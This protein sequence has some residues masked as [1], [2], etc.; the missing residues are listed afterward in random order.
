VTDGRTDGPRYGSICRNSRNQRRRLKL[1]E[2]L[3]GRRQTTVRVKSGNGKQCVLWASA[4]DEAVTTE[5][6]SLTNGCS[7]WKTNQSKHGHFHVSLSPRMLLLLATRLMATV[8][9]R[10]FFLLF[11]YLRNAVI[12]NSIFYYT[13]RRERRNC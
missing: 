11:T 5:C 7:C 1:A 9:D 4:A 13:D 2:N 10:M 6:I 8:I 3:C 12:N